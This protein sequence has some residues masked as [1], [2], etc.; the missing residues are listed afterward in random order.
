MSILADGRWK[1]RHGIGRYALQ[2]L[3]R[4]RRTGAHVEE[5]SGLPLLHP[6]ESVWLSWKIVQRKPDVY[7]SAGF[8]P[9][10]WSPAPFVFTIHDLV[11]L[12]Y[13]G[14]YGLRQRIYYEM[15]VRPATKRAAA[16]LT[17]SEYS[18]NEIL[19]WVRIPEY[20]VVVASPGV[21]KEFRPKVEPL[22]LPYKYFLY[23]GNRKPHKNVP[24][25]LR[26]FARANLEPHVRLVLSGAADRE[27]A[28]MMSHLGLSGRVVFFGDVPESVLPRLYRGAI[29]LLF[30]SLLEGFGLPPLEAMACGTPVV[31]SDASSVPEVVG[32]AGIMVNPYDVEALAEAMRRIAS[33][34]SL[35]AEMATRGLKRAKLFSWDGTTEQIIQVLR[36]AAGAPVSR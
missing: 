30:P 33:E 12:R 3:S 13:P 18:K 16:V 22:R 7:L 21:G 32:K 25:L 19:E 5:L 4:L 31:A 27:T 29:A 11:H 20:K 15:V 28:N 17:V 35:R 26:A 10:L 34:T 2:V 36:E 1:G 8:N 9:P 6:L 14:D 24:R 23:V